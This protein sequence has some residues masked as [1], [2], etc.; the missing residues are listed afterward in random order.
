VFINLLTVAERVGYCFVMD[1]SNLSSQLDKLEVAITRL[2]DS[3]A[4]VYDEVLRLRVDVD[5]LESRFEEHWT[6]M[7]V[8]W[9]SSDGF[10]GEP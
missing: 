5:R 1:E 2:E 4:T 7:P 3:I 9:R 6:V 8:R 10:R